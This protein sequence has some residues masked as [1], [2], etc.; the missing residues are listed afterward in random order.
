[1]T[2]RN[3]PNQKAWQITRNTSPVERKKIIRQNLEKV[4]RKKKE[5][6]KDLEIVG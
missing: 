3:K 2:S 5:P 4:L 6:L 1:M